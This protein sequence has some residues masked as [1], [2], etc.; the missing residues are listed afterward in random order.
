M[1]PNSLKNIEN[2]GHKPGRRKTI[3]VNA[4]AFGLMLQYLMEHEHATIAE[5][6]E[7]SGL[8]PQTVKTWLCEWHR[9]NLVHICGWDRNSYGR[10]T[11][12]VYK[13]GPGKDKAKPK[14]SQAERARTWRA[15][16]KMRDLHKALTITSL[17]RT[18]ERLHDEPCT[19]SDL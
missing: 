17:Y 3:K 15:N 1:H 11:I 14:K 10:P 13:F 7:H 12:I 6:A 2:G 9:M 5:L 19:V 8:H 16:K 4:L 18:E